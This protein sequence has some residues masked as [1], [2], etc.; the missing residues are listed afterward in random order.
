MNEPLVTNVGVVTVKLVVKR[1]DITELRRHP[2]LP[3]LVF[4]NSL[5][6]V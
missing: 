6:K 5:F 2:T 1:H 3:V 4:A